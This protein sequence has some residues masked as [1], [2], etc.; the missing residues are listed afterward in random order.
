MDVTKLRRYEREDGIFNSKSPSVSASRAA[1][2]LALMAAITTR[3][4]VVFYSE[5]GAYT[6]SAT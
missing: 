2:P 4:A 6:L 1:T 5:M 3:Y